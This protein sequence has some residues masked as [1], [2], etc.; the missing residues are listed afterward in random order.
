MYQ[1]GQ[2]MEKATIDTNWNHLGPKHKEFQTLEELGD[3]RSQAFIVAAA[4]P[5]WWTEELDVSQNKNAL[6]IEVVKIF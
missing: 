3:L 6:V 1:D 2:T 5:N 4:S